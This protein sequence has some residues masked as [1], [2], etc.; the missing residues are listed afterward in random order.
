VP[1]RLEEDR[2]GLE[3]PRLVAA[4]VETGTKAPLRQPFAGSAVLS[5]R[6]S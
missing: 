1:Q 5:M 2:R 6:T 4:D 3:Q